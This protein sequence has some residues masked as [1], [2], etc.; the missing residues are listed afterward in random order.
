MKTCPRCLTPYLDGRDTCEKDG[1]R[2]VSADALLP[3]DMGLRPGTQVGEYV[4]E[5]RLGEGGFGSVYRAEHPLIGKRVA[6]KVLHSQ[7]SSNAQIVAR[8]VAEARAVN[9]IRHPNIVDIF[10]FGH[11]PDGRRYYVMELIEGLPLD[12]FLKMSGPVPPEI[13]LPLLGGIAQ[14]L[15]AAHAAGIVHRDLKPENVFI[16]FRE[17]S[18]ASAKLLDFGIAKLLGDSGHPAMDTRTGAPLGTPHYMSPEQC[19]GRPVDHRTDIYS[20]GILLHRVLT[21]RLP[22]ESSDAVELLNQQVSAPAPR[23]SSVLK[24]LPPEMDEPVLRMLEKDPE[25][26][27]SSVTAAMEA[28][29]AAAVSAGV[30]LS[31]DTMDVDARLLVGS[32]QSSRE[33]R[34]S[35]GP[36]VRT[37]HRS[38]SHDSS[39]DTLPQAM[40]IT[41]F[42]A[43]V[44]GS[45]V[46]LQE[47]TPRP[48]QGWKKSWLS[49]VTGAAALLLLGGLVFALRATRGSEPT[50]DRSGTTAALAGASASTS[51]G[52]SA[53]TGTETPPPPPA[54]ATL[55]AEVSLA[56]AS[57]PAGTKVYLQDKLLG[58]APGSVHVARGAE[59]ITLR[60]VA[61]DGRT[62][63]L[64][65]IPDKDRALSISF[66]ARPA[67]PLGAPVPARPKDLEP[68]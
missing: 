10:A 26:R 28:V 6:I 12:R 40:P 46:I 23:M 53:D 35:G 66:L 61:E 57:A 34:V 16:A 3:V 5:E 18:R 8:F 45:D 58:T 67:K 24:V 27:P 25:N 56:I 2:L 37:S 30:Q 65:V 42:P 48:E 9:Q 41:P 4:V 20:L 39:A 14:A 54:T 43:S 49:P 19:R 38:V 17:A 33:P 1:A 47:R 52:A 7:Y 21:D 55:A 32:P 68:F 15:D 62:A 31:S 50:S 29:V 63:V 44:D 22:F 51:A 11:L 36:R 13:A 64:D 60:F 59:T